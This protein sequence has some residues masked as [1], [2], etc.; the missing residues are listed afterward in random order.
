MI[1]KSSMKTL[2]SAKCAAKFAYHTTSM[3][4]T[5]LRTK[6]LEA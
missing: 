4:L 1:L 6:H 3:M 2:F 5:H